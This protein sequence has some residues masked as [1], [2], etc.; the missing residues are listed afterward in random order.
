MKQGRTLLHLLLYVFGFLLLW[1][2][3]LPLE[4]ITQTSQVHYFIL[5]VVFSI[6]LIFLR[7]PLFISWPAKSAFILISLYLIFREA[8][9]PVFSWFNDFGAEIQSN[10]ALV[11]SRNWVELSPGFRSLLFFLLL[12]QMTY[13]LRYWL[14][15]RKRIFVFY[16]M[17]V[18]YVALLDTFTEYEA[19]RAIVRIVIIGF[20]LL[21][22][23][24]FHRLLEKEQ[25][26]GQ[27]QLMKKWAFP[28]TAMIAISVLA[29]YISPKAAPIWPDP[30]PY[31]ESKA[32]QTA[33]A[34]LSKIGY[35]IDDS[36]LGGPF[37]GDDRVVFEVT[38]SSRQYWKIETKDVYTGK[39]WIT[40]EQSSPLE[41]FQFG[42]TFIMDEHL[43]NE[44]NL[45]KASFRF[46]IV[47]P[48]IV[49]PYGF[50]SVT[51]DETSGFLRYD[52]ALG[53]IN[54]FTSDGRKMSL[55]EYTITYENAK[56]SMKE[57]RGTTG[58]PDG[59]KY[60]RIQTRYT[61]LPGSFPERIRDLA[62]ELTKDEDNWFD[63]AKAI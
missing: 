43:R 18:F 55:K 52:P 63:K 31:I 58:L 19:N 60:D 48:H 9:E 39:G 35:G 45:T 53:K 47:Y 2:W 40:S 27:S 61:Q 23:L 54:S 13:L 28:L 1:E 10:M 41:Q 25:F 8:N 3:L 26:N 42:E 30:V 57:L 62:V 24:F 37:I 6:V 32:D 20:A 5:F 34:G 44:G 46:E 51:G 38:T 59:E 36:Q 15:V 50:M 49:R 17:T 11:V 14:T 33:T 7:T 12:W 4:Q 56:Y 16:A 22:I 29:G 21:G